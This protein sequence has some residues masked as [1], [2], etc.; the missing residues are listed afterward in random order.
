MPALYA[1]LRQLFPRRAAAGILRC[2]SHAT[3]TAPPETT[4]A[5]KLH[6]TAASLF[7]TQ[8]A[9]QSTDPGLNDTTSTVSPP[10]SRSTTSSSNTTTSTR[11][12]GRD[13]SRSPART[14]RTGPRTRDDRCVF[15]QYLPETLVP[16]DISG[17]AG[18]D[19]LCRSRIQSSALMT[20]IA[21]LSYSQLI[22]IY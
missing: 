14:S 15:L 12:Q 5:R 4:C 20:S 6:T 9:F 21:L 7:A 2:S 16:D 18:A 19:E 17:L 1:S 3:A 8:D 10:A 22:A 11:F 13:T